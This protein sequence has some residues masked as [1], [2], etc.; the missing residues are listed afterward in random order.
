[1]QGELSYT[2]KK[3]L[4]IFLGLITKPL[5][6]RS[7]SLF[8][9]SINQP[10]SGIFETYILPNNNPDFDIRLQETMDAIKLVYASIYSNHARNYFKA[11]DHKVEEEKMAVI[12]QEVVGNQF[13]GCYY[14]HISGTAQ[15]HNFYPVAHMKPDE[16][17]AVAALGLGQYV[18]E[19]E[20]AFRFSPAYPELE[21]IS[22][23]DYLKVLR[24]TFMPLI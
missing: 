18:V 13:D 15:S 24:Y 21:I 11:I 9:D 6:I 17:F 2:L 12:I 14:P 1:L 22:A 20:K 7:S 23:K 5:A 4:K 3:R 16:G 10:F 8:E 19:G